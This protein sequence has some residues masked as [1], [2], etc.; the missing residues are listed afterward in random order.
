YVDRYG[1]QTLVDP[2][3][4]ERERER[5]VEG[6]IEST[7]E[8]SERN[9]LERIEKKTSTVGATLRGFGSGLS[10]G[11][12]DRLVDPETLEADKR[13][14]GVARAFGEFGSFAVPGVG[15][16]KAGRLAKVAKGADAATD[17]V[18]AERTAMGVA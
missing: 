10:F 9:R 7:A 2:G 12:T 14:R 15:W 8:V 18:R 4:I 5:G 11:L 17:I 3:I 1:H 13:F 6:R 16:T